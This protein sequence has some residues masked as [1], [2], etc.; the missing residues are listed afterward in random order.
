MHQRYAAIA[1]AVVM[2]LI[3]ANARSEAEEWTR[4]R[5]ANGA[6]V[7]TDTDVPLKWSESENLRWKVE[8]PGAGSS[9]PII[10]GN[11]VFVTCYSGYG[12]SKT[13][14]GDMQALQRHLV[15]V[16]RQDGKI[17]LEQEHQQSTRRRRLSWYISE[18]GYASST[19]LPMANMCIWIRR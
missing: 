9:S 13:N 3:L 16:N 7:S 17:Y 1:I 19:P 4:F 10:V 14:P 18:H 11:R 6:G 5:G 15:C 2:V 8:L 12:L